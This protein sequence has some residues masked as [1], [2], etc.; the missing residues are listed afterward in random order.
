MPSSM[1]GRHGW[2]A[3]ATPAFGSADDGYSVIHMRPSGL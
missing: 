2:P 3:Y 1:P